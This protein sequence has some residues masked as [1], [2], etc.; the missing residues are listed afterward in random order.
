MCQAE[1]Y[2]VVAKSVLQAG[3][4]TLRSSMVI[5]AEV[6]G[7]RVCSN[8]AVDHR[9]HPIC[10]LQNINV[11]L[12][13]VKPR[14]ALLPDTEFLADSL[15]GSPAA[16]SL[17]G[18]RSGWLSQGTDYSCSKGSSSHSASGSFLAFSWKC[19]LPC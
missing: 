15:H 13:L 4:L 6:L 18:G 16:G 7:T 5:T 8:A 9:E 1:R 12:L 17:A 11:L 3:S 14:V 19:H 2:L 10:N